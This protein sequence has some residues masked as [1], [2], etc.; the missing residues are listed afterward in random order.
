MG[1]GQ[2][3]DFVYVAVDDEEMNERAKMALPP[4]RLPSGPTTKCKNGMCTAS[5][6]VGIED[7]E[8][9]YARAKDCL[10]LCDKYNEM[11][12][13]FEYHN[14][15][16]N[17]LENHLFWAEHWSHY[18]A[19]DPDK[20]CE[21]VCRIVMLKRLKT[22]LRMF[23]LNSYGSAP[24]PVKMDVQQQ[25][26]L[27]LETKR[28]LIKSAPAPDKRRDEQLL[29]SLS[30]TP[31][32]PDDMPAAPEDRDDDNPSGGGSEPMLL[33]EK[34]ASVGHKQAVQQK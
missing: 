13:P 7:F 25:L 10:S 12:I 18:T 17:F 23:R 19:C 27:L 16:E 9:L 11:N 6:C 3:Q 1:C 22:T 29:L 26:R 33:L 21:A 30:N 20:R 32:A 31:R 5:A 2:S 28:Q 34:N 24:V 14:V 15:M 8:N 4:S